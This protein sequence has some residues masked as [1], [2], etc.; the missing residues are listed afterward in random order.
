MR[1][2]STFCPEEMVSRIHSQRDLEESAAAW[3]FKETSG[4]RLS[5]CPVQ[6]ML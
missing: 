6:G 3:H 1:L 4:Q 2:V 5:G